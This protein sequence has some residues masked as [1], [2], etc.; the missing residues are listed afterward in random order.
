VP[1]ASIPAV[2]DE[3]RERTCTAKPSAGIPAH[4]TV[5]VPF[6]PP[7]EIDETLIDELGELASGVASFRFVLRT[8]G[9]FE[10]VLWL[11]PEPTA[12]FFALHERIHG[13][14]PGFRS[15]ATPSWRSCRT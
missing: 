11:A 10:R 8:F 6:V 14:F 4:I 7:A 3:W 2:V 1:V 15:T 9:R 5:A 12:P 13:R